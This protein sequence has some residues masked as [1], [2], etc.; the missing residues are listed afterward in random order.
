[1]DYY[2]LKNLQADTSMRESIGDEGDGHTD[3]NVE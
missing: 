2:R 3:D 1:M